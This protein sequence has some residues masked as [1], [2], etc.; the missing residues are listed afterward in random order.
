MI[1]KLFFLAI[2]GALGYL[3]Y[4]VWNN[5][6]VEEK[7]TVSKKVGEVASDAK[8]L[9]HRAA[10]SLTD[11]AKDAIK[12]MDDKEPAEKPPAP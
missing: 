1:K 12:K 10:D 2:L 8:D 6:S 11:N 5:L 4:L 9:A 7:T 3:G